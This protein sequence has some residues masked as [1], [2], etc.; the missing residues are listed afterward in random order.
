L[1]IASPSLSYASSEEQTA[2]KYI[3]LNDAQ[4]GSYEGE[5]KLWE[6]NAGADIFALHNTLTFFY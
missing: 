5:E 6:R 4:T 3:V 1:C 2:G